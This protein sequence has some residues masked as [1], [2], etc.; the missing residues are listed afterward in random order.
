MNTAPDAT[1]VVN[2]FALRN[3]ANPMFIRGPMRPSQPP[4]HLESPVTAEI[5]TPAPQPTPAGRTEFE[6]HQKAAQIAVQKP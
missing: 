2:L 5:A 3:R 6:L 4:T 1:Q